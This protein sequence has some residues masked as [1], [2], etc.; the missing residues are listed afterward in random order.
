[1]LSWLTFDIA[2]V[3]VHKDAPETLK[4]LRRLIFNITKP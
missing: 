4:K 2:R 3:G 1:V